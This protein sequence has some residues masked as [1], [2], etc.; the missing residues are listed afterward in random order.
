MR[1]PTRPRGREAVRAALI[2][3]SVQLFADRRPG[4]VTIRAF[5]PRATGNCY[6][7]GEAQIESAR[8]VVGSSREFTKRPHD[9]LAD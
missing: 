2:D 1:S 7:F 3:A 8:R 6:S 4:Q 5:A 9:L